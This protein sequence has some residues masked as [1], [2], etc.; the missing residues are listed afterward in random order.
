MSA[1]Y[2]VI[3]QREDNHS[4]IDGNSPI[5]G[6]GSDRRIQRPKCEKICQAEI[7]YS[8]DIERSSPLSQAPPTG[9]QSFAPPTFN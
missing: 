7:E 3:A 5:E 6:V 8:N 1:M 2:P 9:P 4:T